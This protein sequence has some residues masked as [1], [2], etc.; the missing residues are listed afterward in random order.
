MCPKLL[1]A[2]LPTFLSL[3]LCNAMF[4]CMRN[5]STMRRIAAV[6]N[7]LGPKIRENPKVNRKAFFH[8]TG[9]CLQNSFTTRKLFFSTVF[10]VA[11]ITM[12][13]LLTREKKFSFV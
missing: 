6:Q 7:I 2:L 3:E 4:R 1:R 9:E 11:M 5:Y 13:L 12:L 8:F 10:A